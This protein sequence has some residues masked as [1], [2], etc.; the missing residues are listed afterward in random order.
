M[1]PNYLNFIRGS[2]SIL[3]LLFAKKG[4]LLVFSLLSMSRVSLG[5]CNPDVT[6][7]TITCPSNIS[8]SQGSG[9]CGAVVTFSTPTATDNCSG[10]GMDSSIFNFTGALDSF[11][12]PSGITSISIEALGA[13]GGSGATGGNS[14]SGGA[15]GKGSKATGTLTVTPGQKLYIQVGGAGST[16][17]GGYNGGGNGGSTNAGGGGGASDVRYP[18]YSTSDRI[19]VGGGGGGGGRAGCE[20]VTVTGARGGDGDGNGNNGTDA[21]T[22]GGFAGGGFGGVGSTFG[23]K[24]IGCGGFLGAD[25]TSGNSSGQGGNGGGGQSC[26]CFTFGSI[27]GGGGGGGGYLG[28]G[29]GGGGSAG[30][31][32]CSGNDKGAGGGGA[33]GSSNTGGVTSGST[34]AGVQSGNG[35]VKITWGTAGI[36]IT[37]IA[38]SA[39]GSTFPIGTTTNTFVAT[40]TSGNS[41]TCSFTVTVTSS[42]SSSVVAVQPSGSTYTGGVATNLYLGY[43]AIQDTLKSIGLGSNIS[44]SP[45]TNLSCT[46]SCS[47]TVFTPTSAG[48][49]TF[50][51]SN[52]CAG[53]NAQITICVKDIRVPNT[54]GSRAAVY[55]CHKEPVANTTKTLAVLL[56]GIPGHFQYH[57]GDKLG[58]CGNTCATSKRDFDYGNVVVDEQYLEVICTPNP[59]R[60]S[61]K[62][63]YLSNSEAKAIVSIYGMTGNLIKKVILEGVTDEVELGGNLPNGIYTVSFVQGDKNR[64]FRMIKVD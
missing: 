43:G 18:G 6:K 35:R 23:A 15:G 25:G 16:P 34:I 14:A 39:S 2:R 55:M 62:L 21:S 12:V 52:G 61:F 42:V 50:T 19:I 63:H 27:P 37:Q 59:F 33:G 7:P 1:K 30:T 13:G 22:P 60:Q 31:T 56:R 54:S 38:G 17:T 36:T 8:V 10:S 20:G 53:N 57:P 9:V 41:D 58:V 47:S 29:G 3:S 5:Q 44:W 11:I 24:G 32:G 28:G 64:V 4:L 26:C 45:T 51:A 48:T 49:Y 40:D 46:S